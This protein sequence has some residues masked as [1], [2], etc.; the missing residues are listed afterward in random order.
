LNFVEIIGRKRDAFELE[1]GEIRAFVR[2]AVDGSVPDEQLAAMLMAVC[3]RGMSARERHL[4]VEA[5]LEWGERWRIGDA[6]P[7]AVDKHS[8][9]GVGDGVSLILAPL[10]RACGLPVVMMSGAGLGHT[11]GTLDKLDA[12]PGFSTAGSRKEALAL[13]DACGVCFARQ[14]AEISPA[15]RKLYALRDTTA[16]VPSL[17]LITASIMSK[18]LAVGARRLVLDVKCGAGAFRKTLDDARELA[19]SLVDVGRRAGIA[20]GAMISDMAEPL[21]NRLGTASEARAALEVLR[22]GGDAR[23]R[24][25]TV[26][27]AV[28][29]LVL[30]GRRPDEARGELLRRLGDGSAL[31]PWERVV[32]P[33]GGDPD[34]ARLA[35]P[36][37]EVVVPAPRPGFV[38][39]VSGEALGWIAVA[40]G[41]GRMRQDDE[42]DFAAGLVVHAR[43]GERVDAGTPLATLE[44]GAREAPVD[45]LARRTAEAFVVG[46]EAP[47]PRPLVIERVGDTRR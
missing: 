21:G 46:E 9:G 34:E 24:D 36:R 30:A 26:E 2:G 11:Q 38:Q 15:D 32:R 42:I 29:A 10:L 33:H 44:L 14:S 7:E 16:T 6:C 20:V 47:P 23:L 25:L 43:T 19:E 41:A 17:G 12:I 3:I 1:P 39:A 8:T 28:D 35:R 45:E 5:M 40:L 18:K 22:G 37:A 13:L 31:A 4:L 27:L